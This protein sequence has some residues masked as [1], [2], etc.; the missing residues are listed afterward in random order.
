MDERVQ[1]YWDCTLY[2]QRGV[3]CVAGDDRLISSWVLDTGY[4]TVI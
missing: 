4:K 1:D 2:S 3:Q